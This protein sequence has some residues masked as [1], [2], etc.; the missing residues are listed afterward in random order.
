MLIWVFV[1]V[2]P[3]KEEPIE[4]QP[5][6]THI[7]KIRIKTDKMLRE[8]LFYSSVIRMII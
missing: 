3:Q 7:Q 4:E 5:K 1:R 6:A 8:S 2:N